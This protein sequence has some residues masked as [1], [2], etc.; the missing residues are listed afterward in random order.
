[1][2]SAS[3]NTQRLKIG[4]GRA[5]DIPVPADYDGDGTT[6]AA[7]YR[8]AT[9]LWTIRRSSGGNTTSFSVA[10][11][12]PGDVPAP[13]DYDGDGLTDPAIYRPASGDVVR[14]ALAQRVHGTSVTRQWGL[15]GDT[16][17]PGGLRW[18]RH[19]RPRRLSAL[20]RWLV[21]PGIRHGLH[22]QR[23]FLL[24][25]RGRRADVRGGSHER[26]DGCGLQN[27][28][29]AADQPGSLWGFRRR[30]PGRRHD[31]PARRRGRGTPARD[32]RP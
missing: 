12:L 11:G 1:M 2:S 26:P 13:G 16:P 4:L 6:D 24:G 9:G 27:S 21:H 32:L 14:P 15:S 31:L 19:V 10:W 30:R 5:N 8:P 18:R 20:D 28:G 22:D 29:L 7:V 3:G 23:V 17:V 25:P